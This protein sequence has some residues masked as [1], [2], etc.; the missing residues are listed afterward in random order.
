MENKVIFESREDC[1]KFCEKVKLG[2]NHEAILWHVNEIEKHGYIRKS[3]LEEAEEMYDNMIKNYS[4]TCGDFK[5]A[6]DYINI[7][8]S[9]IARLKK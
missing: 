5:I 3:A 1:Y 9:E 6:V 7:L 8:K 2:M 4:T